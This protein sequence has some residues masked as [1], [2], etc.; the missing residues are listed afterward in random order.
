[1]N[2]IAKLSVLSLAILMNAVTTQ[3]QETKLDPE[4]IVP[5][6]FTLAELDKMIRIFQTAKASNSCGTA[7]LKDVILL[8]DKVATAAEKAIGEKKTEPKE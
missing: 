8:W 1:M 7:C 4:K 2:N 3:A 6:E 5:I